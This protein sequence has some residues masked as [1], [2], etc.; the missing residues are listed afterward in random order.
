MTGLL[1]GH[2]DVIGGDLGSG[3]G[4]RL[5]THGTLGDD[6]DERWCV[7]AHGRHVDNPVQS[8]ISGFPEDGRCRSRVHVAHRTCVAEVEAEHRPG[9]DEAV[10]PR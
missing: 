3:V 5:R 6:V 9:V 8:L 4:A 1:E 7:D 2:G 10:N